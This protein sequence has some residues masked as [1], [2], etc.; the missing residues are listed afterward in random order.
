M[1]PKWVRKLVQ[2]TGGK[3]AGKYDVYIFSPESQKF[4]SRT[5]LA[6]YLTKSRSQ[7]NIDDFDFT[8]HGRN[9]VSENDKSVDTGASPG[10][11]REH[12]KLVRRPEP[13]EEPV[14]RTRRKRT[15]SAPSNGPIKVVEEVSEE[16]NLEAAKLV[17][18]MDF[19]LRKFGLSNDVPV[20]EV[21]P[22][23]TTKRR[24]RQIRC[25]A[26]FLNRA[27]VE[28]SP[29]RR[30]RPKKGFES[31]IKSPK[32]RKRGRP[33]KDS[34]SDNRT[35]QAT[36]SRS[37]QFKIVDYPDLS[38]FSPAKDD[39]GFCPARANKRFASKRE[40]NKKIKDECEFENGESAARVRPAENFMKNKKV[41]DD[42]PPPLNDEFIPY[43]Y[44][45]ANANKP[46]IESI[47]FTWTSIV[48]KKGSGVYEVLDSGHTYAKMAKVTRD[49]LAMTH[50]RSKEIIVDES[51]DQP[52]E[53]KDIMK[54]DFSQGVVRTVKADV[55]AQPSTA[56]SLLK[57]PM[58]MKFASARNPLQAPDKLPLVF[59]DTSS[60]EKPRLVVTSSAMTSQQSQHNNNSN[61]SNPTSTVHMT[62]SQ[63]TR[64]VVNSR[65]TGYVRSPKQGPDETNTVQILHPSITG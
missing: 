35:I 40:Y 61:S 30:G 21:V 42:T 20:E 14:P 16:E 15:A 12:R 29:K 64:L 2:R 49:T 55:H 18:K 47:P 54:I 8:V 43:P 19:G 5:E 23:T 62:P 45:I 41:L 3:T 26:K 24:P 1:P 38:E 9:N 50:S 51:L 57:S 56:Q 22:H 53:N 10:V 60:H 37:R 32:R 11:K 6:A 59:L 34:T 17:V 33:R 4:R 44:L 52:S 36:T 63:K 65:G 48:P 25:P 58:L 27:S 46:K 13:I 31:P 39:I 28:M 7:Y